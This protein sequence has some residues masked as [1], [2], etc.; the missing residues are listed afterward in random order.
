MYRKI[1]RKV[2]NLLV[3]FYQKSHCENSKSVLFMS[4][5]KIII[6]SLWEK[7]PW[8]LFHF[9]ATNSLIRKVQKNVITTSSKNCFNYK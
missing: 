6:H 8:Q 3:E 4:K 2:R 9:S 1:K 5:N 7:L